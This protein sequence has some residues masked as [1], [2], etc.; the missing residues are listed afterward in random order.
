MFITTT[1]LNTIFFLA[2]LQL[3]RQTTA[4]Q[5]IEDITQIFRSAQIVPNVIPAFNPSLLLDVSFGAR[6]VVPGETL[7]KNGTEFSTR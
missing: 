7:T 3:V 5:S 4:A 1:V 2:L 6:T